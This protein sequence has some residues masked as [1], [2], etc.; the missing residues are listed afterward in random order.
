M[1]AVMCKYALQQ[2]VNE[3]GDLFLQES[4]EAA[5]AKNNAIAT[6]LCKSLE[7][8]FLYD[9]NLHSLKLRDSGIV[10]EIEEWIV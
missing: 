9:L 7:T 10:N 3:V 1:S 2:H 4:S 5:E 6:V 8:K